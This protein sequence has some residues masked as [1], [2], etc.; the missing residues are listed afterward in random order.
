M[1][2]PAVEVPPAPEPS[3]SE[4]LTVLE[5][6][7]PQKPATAR[8]Q[9]GPGNRLTIDTRNVRRLRIDRD[10]VPLRADRNIVLQLD[11][12]GFEWLA[13]SRVTEFERS[14]NGVWSPVKLRQ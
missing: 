12:Q 13:G 4:Y 3:V 11:G 5:R 10:A 8:A 6:Y 9:T 7:E 14:D 2:P 1:S